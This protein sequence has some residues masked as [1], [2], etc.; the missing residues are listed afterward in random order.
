MNI[1]NLLCIR[2][3]PIKNEYTKIE[4]KKVTFS[5][6]PEQYYINQTN[7]RKPVQINYNFL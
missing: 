3:K 2:I 7:E 6:T 5:F 1:W 4:S